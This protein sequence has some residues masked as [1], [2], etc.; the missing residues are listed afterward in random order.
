MKIHS[1]SFNNNDNQ[2]GQ[3]IKINNLNPIL[4]NEIIL[5]NIK[6]K[7]KPNINNREKSK[8]KS[9]N[10]NNKNLISEST[11]THNVSNNNPNP[12]IQQKFLKLS[13]KKLSSLKNK[14]INRN[15]INIYQNALLDNL[16]LIITN[17][18]HH[19]KKIK[20]KN[21]LNNA[22]S[23]M[24]LP[25]TNPHST[26][27][28]SILNK[29]KGYQKHFF[30]STYNLN[31][32]NDKTFYSICPKR[33]SAMTP[34]IVGTPKEIKNTNKK[35]NKNINKNKL[36]HNNSYNNFLSK[37]ISN[38]LQRK[39]HGE[40]PIFLNAPV[41]FVKNFKSNSEKERDEKN[42][43]ALF[44]LRDFLDIYWDK[45]IDLIM[46]F[47]SSYQIY[48]EEYYKNK[49]LENFAHFIY[50]NINKDTNVTKGLIETRIPMKEII[51]KGIKYKNYCL[52]KIR[53]SKSMPKIN[54][55]E[56]KKFLE[57]WFYS[58]N[59]KDKHNVNTNVKNVFLRKSRTI[60]QID[61]FNFN[62]FTCFYNDNYI[63]NEYQISENEKNQKMILNDKIE[64]FRK[65]LNKNYG[66]KV[67]NKFLKNYKRGEKLNFFSKRKV[68]TIDI[69]DKDNLVNNLNKQSNFYK[70]K[71][72]NFSIRN[73]PSI[74]TFSEK[75]FK[76]LYNELN[77]AKQNYIN[78]ENGNENEINNNK[79]EE[80]NIWVKMYEDVKKNKFERH[81]ELILK[82]KK[83]LLEYIIFQYIQERK[84]F[85]KELL[86]K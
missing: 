73:N 72:T 40:I 8:A 18:N 33:T 85:E 84:D 59:S 82:K 21:I 30:S 37:P 38:I 58:Q 57:N 46:E 65:Y 1:L 12:I 77:E 29:Y 6:S 39:S 24:D 42:S 15:N 50:D 16:Q 31:L 64:K 11:I 83:K 56:N 13:K 70:L 22:E 51:D 36:H 4:K 17:S 52:R 27:N 35:P 10:N 7:N 19:P 54:D 43:L 47:F 14:F 71:S 3:F 60:D 62:K 2:L 66:V 68:G 61:N 74:H 23:Q 44:R 81:P 49:S 63:N 32:N 55:K 45:R 78:N 20:K 67:N 79:C 25:K 34:N 41:T 9:R 28:N 86:K 80:N 53:K 69:K 75:D 5:E 48:G 26:K 76:E